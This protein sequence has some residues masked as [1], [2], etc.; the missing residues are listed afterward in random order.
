MEFGA[1]V[2]GFE[3]RA[4]AALLGSQ[5]VEAGLGQSPVSC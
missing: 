4:E 3:A 1:E 2:F 5:G